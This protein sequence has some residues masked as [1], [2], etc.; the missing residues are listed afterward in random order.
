MGTGGFA[1]VYR[2]KYKGERTVAL[3]QP[4]RDCAERDLVRFVREVQTAHDLRRSLPLHPPRAASSAARLPPLQ[5]QTLGALSHPNIVA[6][7]GAVWE[8]SLMLVLEWAEGGSVHAALSRGAKEAPAPPLDPKSVAL[9]VARGMAYLHSHRH[10][11][12]DLKAANV[13][14]DGRTPPTA[15]VAD[16]GLSRSLAAAGPLSHVGTPL[17]TAPEVARRG[18][19][20]GLYSLSCDVYSYAIL[21]LELEAFPLV[22]SHMAGSRRTCQRMLSGWRPP[23]TALR[24]VGLLWLVQACWVHAAEERPSFARIVQLLESNP[25]TLL[26]SN[27]SQLLETGGAARRRVQGCSAFGGEAGGEGLRPC[28]RTPPLVA[29]SEG[30]C[31]SYASQSAACAAWRLAVASAARLGPPQ[32]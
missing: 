32:R 26:E 20:G 6:F 16:F 15:K 13:L 23:P 25:Q 1:T 8:P 2:A 7:I 30:P 14:L 17:W 19:D 29:P 9:D 22:H 18:D 4:H 5:V 27:P 24:G 12:R 31:R 10:A 11:H 3:K 28:L 21:L